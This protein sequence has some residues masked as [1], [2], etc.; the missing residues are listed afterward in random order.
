MLP[1]HSAKGDTEM[2]ITFPRHV[3]VEHVLL[4][5]MAL[6]SCSSSDRAGFTTE[7]AG[8]IRKIAD[9]EAQNIV[10]QRLRGINDRV[11]QMNERITKLEA[12]RLER[13]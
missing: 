1:N 11:D 7:Q 8:E 10:L 6:G 3:R 9:V 4:C 12:V 13:K 5:A 2:R